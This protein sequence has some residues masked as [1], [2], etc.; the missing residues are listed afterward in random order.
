[1]PAFIGIGLAVAAA[2]FARLVGFDR[3]RAFYPIV[4]TVIASYYVLF[5]VMAGSNAALPAELAVFAIFTFLAVLGFRTSLWVVVA[6]LAL[7][8]A[9]DFAREFLLV[10]QGIPVWWPTFCLAY[11]VSAAAGL[12]AILLLRNRRVFHRIESA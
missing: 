6:G 1:M 8:G 11:D 5:A 4:L 10:G 12:S 2:V 9:F 7:H 3:D